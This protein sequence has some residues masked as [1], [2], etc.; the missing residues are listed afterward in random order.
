MGTM[1]VVMPLIGGTDLARAE[2]FIRAGE[3]DNGQLPMLGVVVRN[4]AKSGTARRLSRDDDRLCCG[5]WA[6]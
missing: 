6:T 2:N 1:L 4:D 3:N 5:D